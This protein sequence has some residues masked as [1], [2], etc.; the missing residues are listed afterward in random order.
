[1]ARR[2][3]LEPHQSVASGPGIN[4]DATGRLFSWQPLLVNGPANPNSNVIPDAYGPGIVMD[5][6]S[7]PVQSV[8]PTGE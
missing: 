4:S 1:M 6:Y 3:L 8:A 7:R 2:G 5:Q